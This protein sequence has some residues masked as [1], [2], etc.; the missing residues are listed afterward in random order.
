MSN[1]V[2]LIAWP[3]WGGKNTMM[4]KLIKDYTN[5]F[6]KVISIKSRPLKSWEV[7]GVDYI[8]MTPEQILQE[9]SQGKLIE[10][11]EIG[12]NYYATSLDAVQSTLQS[13]NVIKEM[14]PK[15]L[16]QFMESNLLPITKVIFIDIDDELMR[17]RLINRNDAI[18]PWDMKRKSDLA[19]RQKNFINEYI[20]NGKLNEDNF[21]KV[22]WNL[23]VSEQYEQFKQA[24]SKRVD[25]V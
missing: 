7:D 25:L 6:S 3:S 4:T 12:D 20:Y 23:L 16:M 13:T 17:F 9:Y 1:F 14:E 11:A 2:I 5:L 22:D 15:W 10:Y 21:A 8:H 19:K 24:I 18:T